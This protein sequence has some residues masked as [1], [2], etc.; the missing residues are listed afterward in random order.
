LSYLIAC[1][2]YADAKEADLV[3]AYLAYTVSDDGQKAAADNAGS[4][5]LD[6]QVADKAKGIVD[7]IKA[8]S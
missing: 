4:A 6:P 8:Q 5:P 3:K 2:T 1:P 7:Q